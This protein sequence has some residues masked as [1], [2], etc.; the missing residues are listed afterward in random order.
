MSV[1]WEVLNP[2]RSSVESDEQSANMAVMLEVHDVAVLHHVFLAFLAKLA[3]VAAAYLSAEVHVVG[4]ARGFR[5]NEAALEIG[6][7]DACRLR[8]LSP[9]D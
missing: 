7:D 2:D 8:G 4:K 9:D 6:V 5:L 1:T 3:S